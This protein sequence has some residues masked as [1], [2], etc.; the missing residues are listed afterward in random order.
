MM[1][2]VYDLGALLGSPRT[3]NATWLVIARGKSPVGLAFERFEAQLRVS[4]DDIS[5]D[6]KENGA[7]H[8]LRGAVRIH[9]VLRPIIHVASILE[10][11]ARR[12]HAD[13]LPQE[14]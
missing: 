2:P 10:A 11:I 9:N 6:D 12:A 13:G 3:P 4:P 7:R 5:S 8:H 14:R 1:A